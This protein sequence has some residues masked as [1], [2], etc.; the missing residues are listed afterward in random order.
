MSKKRKLENSF[1]GPEYSFSG[2]FSTYLLNLNY[3][4][5]TLLFI[6]AEIMNKE[7]PDL[8]ELTF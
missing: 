1:K 5:G 6:R 2:Y 8:M 7:S 4:P 3:L